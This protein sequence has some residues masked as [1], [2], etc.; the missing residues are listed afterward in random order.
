MSKEGDRGGRRHARTRG[1]VRRCHDLAGD[2]VD[3]GEQEREE[4]RDLNDYSTTSGEGFGSN[5]SE[6]KMN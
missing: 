5:E 6:C 4:H 3:N 1:G 2:D